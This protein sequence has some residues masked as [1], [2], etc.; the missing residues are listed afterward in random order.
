MKECN[1]SS[2]LQDITTDKVVSIIKISNNEKASK[3][4]D[5]RTKVIQ[6]LGT[7]LL[8]YSRKTSTVALKPAFSLKT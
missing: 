5:M 1:K 7:F 6:E 2:T 4:N 8:N 3:S